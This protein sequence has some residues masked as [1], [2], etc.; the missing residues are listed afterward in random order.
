MRP[1]DRE[2][3]RIRNT[4]KN[5]VKKQRTGTSPSKLSN[6]EE[7][8][9]IT[10]RGNL[11]LYR[12][13]ANQLWLCDFRKYTGYSD[14]GGWEVTDKEIRTKYVVLSAEKSQMYVKDNSQKTRL[15][16][17]RLDNDK[18]GIVAYAS[19]G[20]SE[21]LRFDQDGAEIGGT[22]GWVIESG[23]LTGNGGVIRTASAGQRVEISGEYVRFFSASETIPRAQ[24]RYYDNNGLEIDSGDFTKTIFVRGAFQRIPAAG[25]DGVEVDDHFIAS[26]ASIKHN[27]TTA[28]DIAVG[29]HLSASSASIENSLRVNTN[30]SVGGE[31]SA[32]D[33]I[34]IIDAKKINVGNSDDLQ[35]Y[36]Q[37]DENIILSNAKN[38]ECYYLTS[39]PTRTL[40]WKIYSDRFEIQNGG[41]NTLLSASTDYVNVPLLFKSASARFGSSA[42][43]TKFDD[44]GHQT[45]EGDARVYHELWIDAN[46]F[47]A[48]GTKPATL[49]EYGL[50]SAWEFSDLTDDTLYARIHLPDNIDISEN[51][52]TCFA[53]AT[54]AIDA[55]CKWQ[56]E[57]Q[58]LSPGDDVDSNSPDS[59]ITNVVKSSGTA[60]ALKVTN[61]GSCSTFSETDEILT[62]RIKRRADSVSDT[63]ATDAYLLGI[64]IRYVSNKLGEQV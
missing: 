40:G 50:S 58:Y 59:T 54:P 1:I 46:S 23:Y 4:K 38:I 29:E 14:A 20:V 5:V 24:I 51:L 42:S 35:I 56:I 22:N 44:T 10:R 2:L 17:G 12:K 6:G 53:W 16:I 3:R 30:I 60:D 11:R 36:H 37:S 21:L 9:A 7:E 28:S 52:S 39:F 55:Y 13:E 49:V 64:Y 57:T 33:D 34:S 45:M 61:I 31:I 25:L 19:D 8:F 41:T 62:M 27:L 43:Y 63:L 18:Y 32:S 15:E 47:Q 26:S 48:P